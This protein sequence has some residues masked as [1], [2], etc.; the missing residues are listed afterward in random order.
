MRQEFKSLFPYFGGKSKIAPVVWD[1]LGGIN[2]YVEPFVGSGAC[3][4]LMPYTLN[5]TTTIN[6]A[7]GLMANLW[8]SIQ[9][10]HEAVALEASKLL[11]ETDLHA[12]ELEALAIS[13]DLTKRLE[14]DI[15]YF[16]PVIAGRYL[17]GLCNKIGGF[18]VDGGPWVN[19]NGVL[20][21]SRR[22]ECGGR[23]I[24]RELPH[25]GNCGRG[26]SRELTGDTREDYILHLMQYF[27]SRL[28]RT[29]IACGDW[30]RVCKSRS[31]TTNHGLTGI[32]LDPPYEVSGDL[33]KDNGCFREVV[34]WAASESNNPKLRIVLAGYDCPEVDNILTGW[35]K[36]RWNQC[37]GYGGAKNGSRET[38]WA[39]PGC[40]K[41]KEEKTLEKVENLKKQE[42]KVIPRLS[43][44]EIQGDLFS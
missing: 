35:E 43:P 44:G 33:Y 25:L 17:W 26:I 7:S 29:R 20:T 8:R 24:S 22:I 5:P 21:D 32:F 30:G 9:R 27:V 31:V 18:A 36:V 12:C 14:A 16:N 6:D 13:D 37:F 39:S 34:E 1:L 10:D 23:G 19:H 11:G 3:F 41:I 2:N 28:E 38:I 42:E 15:D 4:F 40:L